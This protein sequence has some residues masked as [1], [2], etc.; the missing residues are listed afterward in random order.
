MQTDG[1]NQQ[2]ETSSVFIG[3]KWHISCK[4]YLTLQFAKII[5]IGIKAYSFNV[6]K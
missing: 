3:I 2:K 4:K 6:C 1:Q 5:K